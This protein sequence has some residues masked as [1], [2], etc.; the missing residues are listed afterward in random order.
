MKEIDDS[1]FRK[2][3]V[4]GRFPAMSMGCLVPEPLHPWEEKRSQQD[5]AMGEAIARSYDPHAHKQCLTT[6]DRDG[7]PCT[8]VCAH[9]GAAE[10]FCK[11]EKE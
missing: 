2:M 7:N 4:E 5:R 10:E 3:I 8:P 6:E 1:D 9:C 11:G